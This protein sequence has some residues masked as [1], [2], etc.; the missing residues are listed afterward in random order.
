MATFS[1]G[2]TEANDVD[3]NELEEDRLIDCL[4]ATAERSPDEIVA[5]VFDEVDRFAGEAPQYDDI[6]LMVFRRRSA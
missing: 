1:D 6:T 4:R 5:A 2:V 3:G